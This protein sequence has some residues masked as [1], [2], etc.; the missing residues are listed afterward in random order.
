MGK[1]NRQLLIMMA[2]PMGSGKTTFARQLAAKRN[3]QR[4]NAD[5]IRQ[6]LFKDYAEWSQPDNKAK[7]FEIL[8]S[9]CL[10]ALRAGHS[11]IR[12]Y[13]HNSRRGRG[14]IRAMADEVGA[15]AG[16]V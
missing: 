9:R 2:G 5:M 8:D 3:F 6:E 16:L 15:L 14:R 11:V 10:Q 4:I 7:V 12:D 13:Q 1:P